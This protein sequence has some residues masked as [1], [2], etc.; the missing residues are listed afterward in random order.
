MGWY[1]RVYMNQS[2]DSLEEK[3]LL[4]SG[5]YAFAKLT[6]RTSNVC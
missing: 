6:A 2:D 5:G 4:V 1:T 3:K